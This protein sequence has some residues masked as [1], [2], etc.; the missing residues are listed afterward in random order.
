MTKLKYFRLLCLLLVCSIIVACERPE[1]T[2]KL[3][4]EA[5]ETK[6]T[7]LIASFEQVFKKENIPYKLELT[8]DGSK[9][10]TWDATYSEKV[11]EIKKYILGYGPPN[12]ENLCFYE[13]KSLDRLTGLLSNSGIPF[14]TIK[15]MDGETCVYWSNSDSDKVAEVYPN[16]AE[17]RKLE[18]Q[19]K[20]QNESTE[21]NKANQL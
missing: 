17:I 18:K 7:D 3:I 9:K 11:N 6:D 12:S 1:P 16:W 15:K 10:I 19:R 5:I 8:A 21:S 13:K 2:K 20:L 4:S 14:E